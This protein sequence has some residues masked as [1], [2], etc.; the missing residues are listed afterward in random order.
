MCSMNPGSSTAYC[1]WFV[2][3]SAECVEF[4][5]LKP[6]TDFC[7]RGLAAE[8]VLHNTRDR[9]GV[10]LSRWLHPRAVAAWAREN[11]EAAWYLAQ[12]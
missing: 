8:L 2:G 10:R 1:K 6:P 12:S 7:R 9:V 11:G 3:C 5:A 4:E